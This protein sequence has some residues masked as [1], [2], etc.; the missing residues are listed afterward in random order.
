MESDT[1]SMLV[2]L[3]IVVVKIGIFCLS[4]WLDNRPIRR[5]RR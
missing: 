1:L 3:G 4:H 2:V 5:K